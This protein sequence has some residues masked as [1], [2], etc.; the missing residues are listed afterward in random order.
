MSKSPYNF[1]SS[2]N[3][4]ILE[5]DCQSVLFSH[6]WMGSLDVSVIPILPLL[7]HIPH[8]LIINIVC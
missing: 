6:T 8:D 3:S 5:Y 7:Y 2:M 1:S 4:Y